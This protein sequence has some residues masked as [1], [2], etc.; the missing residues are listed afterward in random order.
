MPNTP[1]A[2]AAAPAAFPQYAPL[3][4]MGT[5]TEIATAALVLEEVGDGTEEVGDGTEDTA[6]A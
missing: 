5:E 2:A 6:R 1:G 4:A 3:P